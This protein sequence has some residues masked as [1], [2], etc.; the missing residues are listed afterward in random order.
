MLKLWK[1]VAGGGLGAEIAQ[2]RPP[3]PLRTQ[4]LHDFNIFMFSHCIRRLFLNLWEPINEV[5]QRIAAATNAQLL[6]VQGSC[7]AGSPGR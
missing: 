7:F 5:R 4:F 2:S 3:D 1:I 6:A